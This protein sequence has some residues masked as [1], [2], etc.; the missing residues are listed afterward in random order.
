MHFMFLSLCFIIEIMEEK[1][2]ITAIEPQKR[3]KDRYNIYADGAYVAALGAEAVVRMN[4]KTGVF[5]NQSALQRAV[6]E[7]NAQYA[8]DRAVSLLAHSMRT[9][10]ELVRRL[11]EKG[12]AEAAID[13][14]M[15]KLMSYGYVDD[16]VYA[17][18]YVRSA[19]AAGRW[20]RVAV[21]HRLLEKKLDRALIDDA[22]AEYTEEDEKRN[23]R[24]QMD[25]LL[26]KSTGDA[27][28][29]R[30]KAFATL[31]RHGFSYDTISS[32]F[33]EADE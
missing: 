22:L 10:G 11:R 15:D 5:I 4:L 6:L 30:Q 9:R 33:S 26:S 28:K 12:I 2:T 23:A 24:R 13:M 17:K 25:A 7:D 21:S 1:L 3:K 20:G 29:Q 14:A 32:L 18:E 31:T 8:F 19:V 27:R 16:A